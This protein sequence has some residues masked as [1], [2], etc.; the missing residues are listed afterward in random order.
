MLTSGPWA[1][2]IWVVIDQL[3]HFSWGLKD[4]FEFKR[5]LGWHSSW[6][7]ILLLVIIIL[8][9]ISW[10]GF[11]KFV[12]AQM[13]WRTSRVEKKRPGWCVTPA[14]MTTEGCGMRSQ[15]LPQIFFDSDKSGISHGWQG[16]FWRYPVSTSQTRIVFFWFDLYSLLSSRT[17]PSRYFIGAVHNVNVFFLDCEG[18]PKLDL[19]TTVYCRLRD[20]KAIPLHTLNPLT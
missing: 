15:N 7:D 3:Y 8:F 19:H 13:H 9:G 4:P 12:F 11:N 1:V 2:P 5:H 10:P 14:T 17:R 20:V 18:K 6:V 16:M